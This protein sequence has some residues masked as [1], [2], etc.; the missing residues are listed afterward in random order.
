MARPD[1][2][3]RS[4]RAPANGSA[5]INLAG[6]LEYTP[7]G[8]FNGLDSFTYSAN[9]GTVDSAAATVDVTVNAVNDAPVAD[10]D[11]YTTDEDVQLDVLAVDGVLFN[12]SDV[13]GD[14]LTAV[15]DS[16][17]ANGTLTLNPDGSFS[18]LPDAD[19]NG[20]DSF[21]YH[22]NDGVLDS[23]IATV[24]TAAER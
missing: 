12:D 5:A 22:A 2:P 11:D 9:D 23:N 15:L 18:Y 21:T 1:L 4:P 17:V 13:D 3:S 8:D 20:S 6:D 24:T 14:G 19:Y 7:N 16:D 10:D